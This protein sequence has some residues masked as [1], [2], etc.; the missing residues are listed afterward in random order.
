VIQ[1]TIFPKILEKKRERIPTTMPTSKRRS[2]S[3]SKSRK[4]RKVTTKSPRRGSRSRSRSYSKK[5]IA[6]IA[7]ALGVGGL[8]LYG[9][10]KKGYLKKLWNMLPERKKK[11]LAKEAV[12]AGVK[13]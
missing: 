7:S 5:K 10:H 6:A 8:S 12:A 9:A 2:R 13:A 11:E 1:R 3:R 4:S